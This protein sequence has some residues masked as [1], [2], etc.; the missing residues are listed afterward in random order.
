MGD[1]KI[2]VFGGTFNPIHLGHIHIAVE[3]R[4]LFSL[5]KICFVVAGAPPHKPAGNLIPF[6]HR[7]TMVSLATAGISSFV[8]SMIEIE[9]VASPYSI[10]TMAKL[11]RRFRQGREALYFIAGGDSLHEVKFWKDSEKLLTSYNF[12]FAGRP[13][14]EY[15]DSRD[16]LPAK[17]V[18]RVR[19]LTGIS[20]KDLKQALEEES[21]ECRIYL[22]DVAAPGISATGIRNLAASG[23][24]ISRLVPGSVNEYI[25]KLNLYGKQ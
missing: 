12:I 23:R 25:N 11:A 8:P 1:L 7:Y 10:D 6:I 9:P 21:G 22:V 3:I 2:G 24:R 13:G 19:D 18:S 20:R 17:A 5:S 4:K 15:G 16:I 14:F